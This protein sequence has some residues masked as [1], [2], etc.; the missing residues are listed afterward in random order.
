LDSVNSSR[1]PVGTAAARDA[2]TLSDFPN[3]PKIPSIKIALDP[4]LENYHNHATSLE[5]GNVPD[6]RKE[7]HP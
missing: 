6:G 1:V 5:G 3:F 4:I 7:A 2:R